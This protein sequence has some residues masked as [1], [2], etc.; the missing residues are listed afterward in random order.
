MLMRDQVP[1]L[2]LTRVWEYLDI[3]LDSCVYATGTKQGAKDLFPPLPTPFPT[4]IV[5]NQ[6]II[7]FT[8]FFFNKPLLA[9]FRTESGLFQSKQ[10]VHNSTKGIMI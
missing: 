4:Q 3:Y 6:F 10:Y 9:S 2:L 1:E 7:F 5:L 8:L